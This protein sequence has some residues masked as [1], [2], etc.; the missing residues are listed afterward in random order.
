MF[1]GLVL[2]TKIPVYKLRSPPV[3]W[4]QSRF[5]LTTIKEEEEKEKGKQKKD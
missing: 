3:T 5:V 1:T 4:K 2:M